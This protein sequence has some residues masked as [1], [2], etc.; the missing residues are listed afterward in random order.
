MRLREIGIR[1]QLTGLVILLVLGASY[2]VPRWLFD[3]VRAIVEEHE[4]VDLRDEAML[5]GWELRDLLSGL[6]ED[7]GDLASGRSDLAP[8]REA[9]AV[10][11]WD[12]DPSLRG[13]L[14][15]RWERFLKVV[16]F[17]RG[18][19]PRPGT[20]VFRADCEALSP[21][22]G[23]VPSP[24]ETAPGSTVR[25]SR[26]LPLDLS[27]AFAGG[28]GQMPLFRTPAVW[29]GAPLPGPE[30]GSLWILMDLALRGSPRHIAFLLDEDGNFLM[31]PEPD[32]LRAG[33][34]DA[35]F[36]HLDLAE[37]FRQSAWMGEEASVRLGD[38]HAMPWLRSPYLFIEGVPD[39]AF[40]AAVRE[41]ERRDPAAFLGTLARL[42]AKYEPR[43]VRVGGISGGVSEI[44]LLARPGVDP[45]A[46]KAE[47]REDLGKFLAGR[48]PA[49][50]WRPL[51]NCARGDAQLVRVTLPSHDGPAEYSLIYSAFREELISS[52]NNELATLNRVSILLALLAGAIAFL[53][54]LFFVRP[55]LRVA[56]TARQVSA[57]AT[58]NLPDKIEAVRRALP[59]RR[60][61]EVGQIA[62]ALEAL[63]LQVLNAHERLRQLNADLEGRIRERTQELQDAYEQLKGLSV[64]KDEFLASVSHELRQPLNSIFGFLQF[65]E[66]SGLDEEQRADVRKIRNAAIYLRNLISDI[67]DYQKI[68]MG[69]LELE[70]QE[71]DAREFLSSLRDSVEV[72]AREFGNA[73]D[74]GIPGDIG[75]LRNDPQRLQQVLL[76]LLGNACKFTRDGRVTLRAH[77]ERA[78]VGHDWITF[79]VIDTGR[80]MRPEEQQNLF[81]KFKKLSAREGNKSGTGLGLVITRGLCELM[82]GGI[83]FASEFGK[84]STFTVRIPAEIGAPHP[85]RHAAPPAAPGP[86]GQKP[87]AAVPTVLVIDDDPAVHELMS[88]FLG[89]NGYRVLTAANAE[90]GIAAA[91]REMPDAITLDAVMPGRDGWDVLAALKTDPRT[92]PIPVV[93]VTFR[94]ER[95]KG[96][97]LGAADYIVKPIH[98]QGLQ[99]TLDR[100]CGASH[101]PAR[102]VLVIEDDAEARELF[103]RTLAAAGW[104]VIEAENGAEGLKA[105]A[106]HRPDAIILDLMMPVMDG[107][108]FVAEYTRR[109]LDDGS[110]PIPILVVTAKDPTAPERARLNGFVEGILQKG[111]HTQEQLLGE[112]LAMIAR[113]AP[114]T[115]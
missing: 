82:G 25:F 19:T 34:R 3:D 73:L 89:Q 61:D 49:I 71:I 43:G 102:S 95:G 7:I 69:V 24:G 104:E 93:M 83:S 44:R 36:R 1:G 108:E 101:G 15:L 91:S 51:V 98:W 105:L 107:F 18:G 26:V 74:F 23:L 76:N 114:K 38:L 4:V 115:P 16:I 75:A 109:R 96:F 58:E 79:D 31:H 8:L 21:P 46:L 50:G 54:S 106:A 35:T 84:G 48:P 88:R 29:A 94:D 100:L 9:V 60:S 47:I 57:S 22:P 42:R 37:A 39:A 56:A 59:A 103:R 6:R 112:I 32:F 17:D 13:R 27:P 70:P 80:G 10:P 111:G 97:A 113:H 52:I 90:E 77:R 41:F 14:P 85:R 68:V 78:A 5:R 99:K 11:P 28:E 66:M 45:A 33:G 65:L 87:H 81:V 12:L 30:G 2:I 72:Q 67:L 62:R 40:G 86:S 92:A 64:A 53:I 63:L 20:I 55:L 110:A